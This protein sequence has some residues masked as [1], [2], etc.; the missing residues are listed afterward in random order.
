MD[1]EASASCA[2]PRLSVISMPIQDPVHSQGGRTDQK[3]TPR[4]LPWILQA[5]KW[6]ASMGFDARPAR[7]DVGMHGGE[8]HQLRALAVRHVPARERCVRPQQRRLAGCR[9]Q[10][11]KPSRGLAKL[12][13]TGSLDKADCV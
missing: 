6:S 3:D 8:G 7:L 4:A 12:A 9:M 2:T 10:V 5:P 1:E 11:T 13:D